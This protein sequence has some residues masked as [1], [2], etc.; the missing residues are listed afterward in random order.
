MYGFTGTG[1][2]RSEA[3][4]IEDSRVLSVSSGSAS[5]RTSVV[6]ASIDVVAATLRITGGAGIEATGAA[7]GV[8]ITD[9]GATSGGVTGGGVTGGGVTGGGAVGAASTV[10]AGAADGKTEGCAGGVTIS[11]TGAGRTTSA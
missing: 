10:G 9:G 4:A 5:G 3:H 11:A 1:I 7:T 8:S 2:G 6:R